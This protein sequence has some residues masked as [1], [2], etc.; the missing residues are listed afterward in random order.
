MVKSAFSVLAFLVWLAPT[1]L[2]AEPSASNRYDLRVEDLKSTDLRAIMAALPALKKRR[3]KWAD[4]SVELNELDHSYV[5]TF[6]QPDPAREGRVEQNG[7]VEM[8]TH[9]RDGGL[10]VEIDKRTYEIIKIEEIGGP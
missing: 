1:T 5:V 3:P 2:F 9:T 6:W 4:Y 7:Q 10:S 8:L